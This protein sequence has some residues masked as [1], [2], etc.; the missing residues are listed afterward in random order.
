MSYRTTFS[1]DEGTVE[2][3]RALAARW[4]VS[5][6]EVIRRVVAQALVPTVD[7]SH[8][9]VRATERVQ[10]TAPR[11][12]APPV[13]HA[14]RAE[15]TPGESRVERLQR[16]LEREIWPDV[17]ANALGAPLTKAEMEALL[18]YGPDGV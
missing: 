14:T 10:E 9:E 8:R 2:A 4:D 6:A 15:P 3:I 12:G 16:V 13:V 11:W 7:L 18:G 1:L 5:Q 17:P